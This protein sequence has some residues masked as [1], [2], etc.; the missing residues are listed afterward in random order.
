MTI[1]DI[2]ALI[3]PHTRGDVRVDARTPVL[4]TGV[5]DSYHFAAF[6]ESIRTKAGVRIEV[7]EIGVDNFDTPVQMLAFL[8]RRR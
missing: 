5:L 6:L 8:G 2:I 7:D 1:D 4:S 3:V